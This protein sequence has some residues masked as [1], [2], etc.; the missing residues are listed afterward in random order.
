MPKPKPTKKQR[1]LIAELSHLMS[2]LGL[3]Y[4]QIMAEPDP[5]D[6]S[7]RLELAKN[8]IIRS[9][10]ILKYVLMDE[11]LSAII[12]WYYFGKKRGFPQLWKSKRFKLFNHFILERLYLLQ[13]LDLVQNI[14]KIPKWV[15][16]DLA[17]LNELRN[18]IGHSF[19][20]E[21]RRRRP[22][23]KGRIIFTQDGFDHFLEDMYKLSTFFYDRFWRGSPEDTA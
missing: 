23:W 14:H 10:I 2:A 6:R 13:K 18:G 1:T 9:E 8:Q 7:T 17:A 22:E 4:S 21:N 19:F 15:A 3:D 11:F 12:C 16:S 20:P 5:K